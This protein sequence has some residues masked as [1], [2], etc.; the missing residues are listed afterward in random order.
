MKKAKRIVNYSSR[1]ISSTL[2]STLQSQIDK[3]TV[4][5]LPYKE[6]DVI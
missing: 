5:C 1:D 3:V 4:Q 6:I 2:Q